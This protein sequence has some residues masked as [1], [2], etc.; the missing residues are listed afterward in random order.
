MQDVTHIAIVIPLFMPELKKLSLY[1]KSHY[2]NYITIGIFKIAYL[3][4]ISSPLLSHRRLL[5]LS[6]TFRTF[7]Y[8]QNLNRRK[9]YAQ[10]LPEAG[11]S[12]IHQVHLQLVV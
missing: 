10:I 4:I 2:R 11:M 7:R 6:N 3:S 12:N 1:R 9:N 8:K 5:S